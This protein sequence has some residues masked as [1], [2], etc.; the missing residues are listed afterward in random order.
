MPAT[1]KDS[2]MAGPAWAAAT[3][4]VRTKMPAPMMAPMPR[5]IRLMG[6]RDR[7][8]SLL[9]ASFWIWDTDFLRNRRF[10]LGLRPS[11]DIES[12]PLIHGESSPDR[13]QWRG[14]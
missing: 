2:M 1:T 5:L 4:P 10:P 3:W 14:R 11:A 7:F 12:R 6:P 8:S 9:A 13:L